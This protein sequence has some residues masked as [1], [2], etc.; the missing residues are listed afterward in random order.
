VVVE[1]GKHG[2][3]SFRRYIAI[4]R[5][6]A[7]AGAIGKPYPSP[8]VR[9]PRGGLAGV[10]HPQAFSAFSTFLLRQL[11]LGIPRDLE[12]AARIDGASA[13][14]I[15]RRVVLPLSGPALAAVPV[16]TSTAQW[17]SFLWPLIVINDADLRTLTVGLRAPVGQCAVQH[18]LLMAGSV[19]S[20]VPML[21]VFL[22]A[23]RAFV[24]GIALTGLAGR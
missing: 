11:F 19:I 10:D 21:A 20:L 22:L 16:F 3:R 1:A 9:W 24:R 2:A 12:D 6:V 13:L 23:Q 15:Y 8:P 18:Q 5:I 4:Y 17:N 14:A 7:R